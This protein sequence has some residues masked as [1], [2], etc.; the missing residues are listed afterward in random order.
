MMVMLIE[1]QEEK[2]GRH[3]MITIK[4][5]CKNWVIQNS[6]LRI[7]TPSN[8]SFPCY[9]YLALLYTLKY[10]KICSMT[11]S[12]KTDCNTQQ[13]TNIHVTK[14]SRTEYN[15]LKTYGPEL[16]GCRKKF[17]KTIL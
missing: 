11:C 13:M 6:K 10:F 15:I 7:P 2:S 5:K 1:K 9:V 16:Q 8:V 14:L 4:D 12:V 17:E 3:C